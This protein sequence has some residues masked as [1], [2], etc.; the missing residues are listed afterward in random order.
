MAKSGIYMSILL[1]LDRH[2]YSATIIC[3]SSTNDTMDHTLSF[4]FSAKMFM[5]SET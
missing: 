4:L 3:E 2:N 5:D 1:C